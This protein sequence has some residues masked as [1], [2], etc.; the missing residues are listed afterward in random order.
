MDSLIEPIRYATSFFAI[1]TAVVVLGAVKSRVA[2]VWLVAAAAAGVLFTHVTRSVPTPALVPLV[3]GGGVALG[4]ALQ[5]WPSVAARF[6]ALD[7]RQWRSLMLLRAVFGALILAA[8]AAGL[9]P[10]EFAL[11]AGLGDLFVGGLALALPG[12]LAVGGHRGARLAVFG[13]GLLDF[14]NVF[15]LQVVVLVPWLAATHS[16]GISLLLPWVAVPL[17]AMVN[18][19]GLRQVVKELARA[20][21]PAA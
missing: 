10:A 18:V 12:S 2:L 19:F 9:M 6:A 15:R 11:P 8:G 5:L 13:I 20:P 7:D 14:A 17:L 21:V 3:A 4:V 16:I 1:V